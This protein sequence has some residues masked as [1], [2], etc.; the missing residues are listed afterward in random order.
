MMQALL[1]C[2]IINVSPFLQHLQLS[3]RFADSSKMMASNSHR[4]QNADYARCVDIATVA[5][6][7]E[8]WK[9]ASIAIASPIIIGCNTRSNC[10]SRPSYGR[11][12]SGIFLA[13]HLANT[14]SAWD[15]AKKLMRCKERR[16]PRST[17]LQY[18]RHYR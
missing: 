1:Q 11:L 10:S 18:W 6:L 8:L 3:T 14:G 17:K 5:S 12:V 16:D 2:M 13:Y 15:N 9:S 7:K 4:I